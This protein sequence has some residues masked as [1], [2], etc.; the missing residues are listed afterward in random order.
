MPS[1]P[2]GAGKGSL[3][4]EKSEKIAGGVFRPLVSEVARLFEPK[5][6]IIFAKPAF[7]M[8]FVPM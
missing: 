4:L 1:H 7:H 5:G 2:K 3:P 8:I 6:L